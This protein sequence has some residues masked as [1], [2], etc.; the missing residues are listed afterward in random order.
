MGKLL[1]FKPA[2]PGY[3]FFGS[4]K[5]VLLRLGGAVRTR[6]PAPAGEAVTSTLPKPSQDLQEPSFDPAVGADE[7]AQNPRQG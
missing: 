4:G 3:R 2:P 1:S 6:A 5:G 7:A